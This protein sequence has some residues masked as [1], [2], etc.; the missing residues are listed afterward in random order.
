MKRIL[1]FAS[2][3]AAMML[4]SC[5]KDQLTE[6]TQGDASVT[7]TVQVPAGMATKAIADGMT[8]DKLLYEVYTD[9]EGAVLIEG[10]TAVVNGKANVTVNLVKNQTY[11]FIFWA[12]AGAAR[13]FGTEDL[14]KVT[15]DYSAAV[16]N[17][18]TLDAF[19]AVREVVVDGP[20]TET[21]KLYR[22][23]AQVNFGT[24][25]EDLAAAEKA[26]VAPV[27]SAIAVEA[28]TTLNTLTGEVDELVAVEFAD[29]AIPAADETLVIKKEDGTTAS[30][31]YM[32]T[33]Y[34]LVGAEKDIVDATATI[35][36][37]NGTTVEVS[38][39]NLPVQR[40]Y[41][42]NIVG[43]IL[44][45]TV[46]FDIEVDPDFGGEYGNADALKEVLANGG[47]YTLIESAWTF[48]PGKTTHW[49]P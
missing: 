6:N 4:T 35:T 2:A 8:V 48:L 15:V 12:Q 33:S 17:D 36:L 44:T 5:V 37:N 42:T 28:A 31:K 41:R 24:T 18:E 3:C 14:R 10:E 39:P 38:V 40:N 23:F 7:F 19:Y 13:C 27:S 47:E 21:V 49:H 26:G 11:N 20:R 16:A 45:N 46:D 32:A 25:A 22:P 30:Y 29:N 34:V 1:L 43:N 9:T